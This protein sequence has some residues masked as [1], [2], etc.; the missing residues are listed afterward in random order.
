[1]IN[2]YINKTR[3]VE[4]YKIVPVEPMQFQ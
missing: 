3:I 4:V 2:K 1:L